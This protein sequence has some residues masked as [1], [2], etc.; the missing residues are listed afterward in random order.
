MQYAIETI[1][2]SKYIWG[3]ILIVVGAVF[4]LFGRVI[5]NAVLATTTAIVVFVIG[6][7]TTFEILDESNHDTSTT[8]FWVILAVWAVVGIIAGLVAVKLKNLGIFLLG[9]MTGFIISHW[10]VTGFEVPYVALFWVIIGVGTAVSAVLTCKFRKTFEI[11]LT[12]ILGSVAMIHGI[13]V[14]LGGFPTL[15]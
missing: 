4:S 3:S 12:A 14:F 5:L 7:F 6:I 10:I 13:N 9:G 1:R 11:V 8:V 2:D 15:Y